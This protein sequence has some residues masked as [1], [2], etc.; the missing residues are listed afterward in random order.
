MFILDLFDGVFLIPLICKVVKI[1]YLSHPIVSI[2]SRIESSS[3]VLGWIEVCSKH[4]FSFL[5]LR[6][7]FFNPCC[8]Q[9]FA[10]PF[11]FV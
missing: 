1:P 3:I 7:L 4:F 8:L 10:G 6:L 5:R 9:V 2:L 11:L